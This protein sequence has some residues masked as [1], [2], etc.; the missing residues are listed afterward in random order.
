MHRA[1]RP[2]AAAEGMS[3][4]DYIRAGTRRQSRRKAS[5]RGDRCAGPCSW[6]LESRAGDD[7]QDPSGEPWRLVGRRWSTCLRVAGR[8][9]DGGGARGL[10]AS[11]GSKRARLALGAI[12]GRRRGRPRPPR[13][14]FAAVRSAPARHPRRPRRPD[15]NAAAAR[16]PPS[17][18]TDRAWELRQNVS[19]YDGLYV[20]PRRGR[21]EG[22]RC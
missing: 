2:S 18:R 8:V 7:H 10:L 3:L 20:A 9:P 17:A 19:F 12:S 4:S 14:R 11:A 1:S 6:A 16:L 13:A 22:R 15:G 5:F 21:V